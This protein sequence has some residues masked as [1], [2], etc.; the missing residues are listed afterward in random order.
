MRTEDQVGNVAY[1]TEARA[2]LGEIRKIVGANAATK[3]TDAAG[4]PL[5][6]VKVYIGIDL[7]KV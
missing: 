2:A 5:E 4:D 6:L 1:L 7:E 3:L